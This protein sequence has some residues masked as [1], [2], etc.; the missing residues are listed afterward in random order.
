[1]L[2]VNPHPNDDN[3][4]GDRVSTDSNLLESGSTSSPDHIPMDVVTP[5]SSSTS[6]EDNVLS[7][8]SNTLADHDQH[9]PET[10]FW[11][12]TS[13][14]QHPFQQILQQAPQSAIPLGQHQMHQA[15]GMITTSSTYPGY[16]STTP[17][18]AMTHWSQPSA[19][20]TSFSGWLEAPHTASVSTLTS[21][22]TLHNQIATGLTPMLS[23]FGT[24]ATP[25]VQST[26]PSVPA[27]PGPIRSRSATFTSTINDPRHPTELVRHNT[28]TTTGRITTP[29]S[30]SHSGHHPYPSPRHP[31][32]AHNVTPPSR[33]PISAPRVGESPAHPRKIF[34]PSPASAISPAIGVDLTHLPL[35]HDERTQKHARGG[36][37]FGPGMVGM[38][39]PPTTESKPPRFKPSKEQLEVLI[40]A[41]NE[42]MNPDSAAREA[43]AKRLGPDVRP[44]TLQIWFQ[45]RRSKS[46]AKERNAVLQRTHRMSEGNDGLPQSLSGHRGDSG[47][48]PTNPGDGGGSGKR[49]IDEAALKSLILGDNQHLTLLPISV[50]S[51]STWT[52]FLMPGSGTTRPDL[53]AALHLESSP[54]SQSSRNGIYLYVRHQSEIFRIKIPIAPRAIT[55]IHTASNPSLDTEAVAI[56]FDL[57]GGVAKFSGWSQDGERWVDVG[58]FTG[59]QA[60]EGGRCELTG[61]K[62]ILVP[63]FTQVQGLLLSIQAATPLD[64]TS[65]T[66]APIPSFRPA[67]TPTSSS[68]LPPTHAM[69]R[70]STLDIPHLATRP[71]HQRQRSVSQPVLTTLTS[72]ATPTAPTSAV[73]SN[74]HIDQRSSMQPSLRVVSDPQGTSS[75]SVTST[76]TA[77][78][79]MNHDGVF[80]DNSSWNALST[81]SLDN[82]HSPNLGGVT[83]TAASATNVFWNTDYPVTSGSTTL[84]TP[85]TGEGIHVLARSDYVSC[86]GESANGMA[87]SEIDMMGGEPIGMTG[88]G[89]S[90]HSES[91]TSSPPFDLDDDDDCDDTREGVAREKTRLGEMEGK[92]NVGLGFGLGLGL[93][94]HTISMS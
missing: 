86:A 42:N 27:R 71:V 63:A 74:G 13:E 15:D 26:F 55:N 62:D 44:K 73:H 45:N 48:Q 88:V 72:S 40:N 58:D 30:S 34:H 2:P 81:P 5:Q 7:A 51:I 4:V 3:Q 23:N 78:L 36:L 35:G 6:L 69:S 1:M 60:S 38:R 70:T 47:S 83:P 66:P 84:Q 43:L 54:S 17:A 29:Q 25:A 91:T 61:R 53:A 11:S 8:W 37:P 10:P 82:F 80:A 87:F 57:A 56:R 12:F 41:Y 59:G 65:N 68:S 92:T 22:T 28:T 90:N 24:M 33:A 52:R 93:E 19:I 32:Q 46:R 75:N 89:S 31:S 67:P 39:L 49:G 76:F 21:P 16:G 64:A 77:S 85:M 94:N 18:T 14:D 20:G 50:L 9:L 79:P